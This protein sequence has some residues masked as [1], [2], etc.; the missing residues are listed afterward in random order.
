MLDILPMGR[1]PS[2]MHHKYPARVIASARHE[3][4]Q[5]LA[6]FDT[7]NFFAAP[8]LFTCGIKVLKLAA[9]DNVRL[10]PRRRHQIRYQFFR[11][12][13]IPVRS[14]QLTLPVVHG[15]P[16]ALLAIAA[17]EHLSDDITLAG[18]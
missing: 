8:L 1:V 11:L 12:A 3:L 10:V 9:P 7:A 6:M 18:C 15:V 4:P 16:L 2:L 17:V 5:E 13:A 14:D